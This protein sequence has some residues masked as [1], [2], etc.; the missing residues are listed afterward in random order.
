MN[1]RFF[2]VGVAA[3]S[4]A[5]VA[6]GLRVGAGDEIRA[7]IVIGAPPPREGGRIAWQVRTQDD[8]FHTRVAAALP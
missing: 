8:D 4:I 5:I 7:A 3:A 2:I 6:I 1:E